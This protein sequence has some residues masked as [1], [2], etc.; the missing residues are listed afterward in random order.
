M[1]PLTTV[2]H[3][4]DALLLE[5]SLASSATQ[6][7]MQLALS[8]GADPAAILR[9]RVLDP[10]MGSGH[11]L[12]EACR[13]LGEAL[14]DAACACDAAKQGLD[15]LDRYEPTLRAYLPSRS[16][17]EYARSR[18]LAIC[19]RLVATHCLYGVD[20]NPLAIALTK[21]SIWLEAHAEGYPLTF[22]DHRIVRGDSLTGPFLGD[23]VHQH[24]ALVGGWRP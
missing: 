6:Q 24:V 14:Y 23:D 17:G 5:S 7:Q 3:L 1:T 20:R 12:I 21:L 4:P 9:L 2:P 15:A 10:A 13:Y 11:F 18:A 22:L 8:A 16:A 19:R